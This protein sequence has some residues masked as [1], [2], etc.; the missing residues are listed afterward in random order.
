[1]ADNENRYDMLNGSDREEEIRIKKMRQGV[2]PD[3]ENE[4]YV[5]EKEEK[6]KIKP[7]FKEKCQNI[8]YHS[9][10]TI[11]ISSFFA[12][13]IIMLTLQAINA[14]KYDTTVMLCSFDYYQQESLDNIESKLVDYIEDIDGDGKKNVSV[15]QAFY[16]ETPDSVDYMGIES[17]MQARIMAEIANGENCLFIIE[18]GLLDDL[19][20]KGV[21]LD[22]RETL[23]I[24]EENAVYGVSIKDS[25]LLAYDDFE[26]T[27]EDYYLAIRVYKEGTDKEL[28]NAQLDALKKIYSE[29]K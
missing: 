11:L 16:N 20:Q 27:R 18:K 25:R 23:S 6:E 28:Y 14:E 5:K 2:I 12:V 10:W 24:E 4:K 19:S 21:F 7:S 3:T 1:M 22:L 9:K 13:A 8:W 17:A 15:Y 26:K 29:I